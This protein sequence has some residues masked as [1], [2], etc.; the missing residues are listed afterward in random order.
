MCCSRISARV[1]PHTLH[2]CKICLKENRFLQFLWSELLRVCKR[3][4]NK[5]GPQYPIEYGKC[6][7]FSWGSLFIQLFCIKQW[8]LLVMRHKICDAMEVVFHEEGSS[9]EMWDENCKVLLKL[10][11]FWIGVQLQNDFLLEVG[12]SRNLG[13]MDQVKNS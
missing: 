10:T 5:K 7:R 4:W 12:S 2:R 11:C 13:C 9:C 3:Y 8:A 6:Y 1:R